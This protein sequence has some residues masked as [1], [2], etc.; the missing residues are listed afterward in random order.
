MIQQ[1]IKNNQNGKVYICSII[2]FG[3]LKKISSPV[4]LFEK[5]IFSVM[6]GSL[7]CKHEIGYNYNIFVLGTKGN[8]LLRVYYFIQLKVKSFSINNL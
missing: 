3:F 7:F 4:F 2:F 5:I 1:I 8:L 6:F